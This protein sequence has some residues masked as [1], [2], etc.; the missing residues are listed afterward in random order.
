METTLT[1]NQLRQ[2]PHLSA[3]SINNYLD[4]GLF[5]RFRKIDNVQAEFVP[6]AM[7][8]GSCIHLILEEF[9]LARKNRQQMTLDRM[10][11]RFREI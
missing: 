5:Y 1:L 6:G 3:S 8:F 4:C 2:R 11:E 10:L 9:H 7:I